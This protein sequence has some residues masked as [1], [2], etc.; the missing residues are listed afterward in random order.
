MQIYTMN[1]NATDNAQEVIMDNKDGVCL[2][3]LTST[4]S[5]NSVD[6]GAGLSVC[7]TNGR[8]IGECLKP[9]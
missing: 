5:T 1:E 7:P 3:I 8:H 2:H 4:D 9:V 6:L